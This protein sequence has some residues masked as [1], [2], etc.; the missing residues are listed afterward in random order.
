MGN[1]TGTSLGKLFMFKP[2][3]NIKKILKMYRLPWLKLG[4]YHI[5]NL[6]LMVLNLRL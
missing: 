1:I 2:Q 3:S 5:E 4:S 6:Q